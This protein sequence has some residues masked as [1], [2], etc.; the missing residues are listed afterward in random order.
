MMTTTET[1]LR[2]AIADSYT[3]FCWGYLSEHPASVRELHEASGVEDWWPI[4][5]GLDTLKRMGLIVLT[6]VGAALTEFGKRV[7]DVQAATRE[8]RAV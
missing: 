5:A 6:D 4:K 3:K 8:L 2:I 7:R 1:I